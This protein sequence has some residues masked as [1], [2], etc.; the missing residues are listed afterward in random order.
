MDA[1]CQNRLTVV[2]RAKDLRAFYRDEKWMAAAVARHIDLLEHSPRRHAW[3]FDTNRPPLAF[4]RT[5]S[6]QWPLTFLLDYD[7]EDEHFKG[8]AKAKNGR[9]RHYQISY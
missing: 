3:Q 9:L 5:I 4:L 7:C 1:Y 6:R 2:G 8:L